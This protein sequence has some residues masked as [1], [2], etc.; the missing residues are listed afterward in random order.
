MDA[1][2]VGRRAVATGLFQVPNVFVDERLSG[3]YDRAK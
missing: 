2:V 3:R 1:M